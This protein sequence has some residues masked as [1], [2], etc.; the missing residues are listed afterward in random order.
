MKQIINGKEQNQ[1]KENLKIN[2]HIYIYI[3]IYL[4][5]Q[6]TTVKLYFEKE[7]PQQSNKNT[8][9]SIHSNQ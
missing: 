5:A 2:K 9:M 4:K 8:S 7:N 3:F 1:T 6:K